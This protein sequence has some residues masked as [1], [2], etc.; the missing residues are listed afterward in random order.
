MSALRS[1][2]ECRSGN[3][4]VEMVLVMPILTVLLFGAVELGNYFYS[5][6]QVVKGVRDGARYASRLSFVDLNCTG[7]SAS[8]IPSGVETAIKEITRTGRI[9]GGTARVRGWVDGDIT[10]TVTCPGTAVT[11]GIYQGADNAPQIN[12]VASV[13]YDSLLDGVGIIDSTYMLNASQQAAVM[14]I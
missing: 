7:G 13:P 3:A 4:A 14:G 11:T 1:L 10:V 8:T 5:E 9:S 2:L 6:H 12:V